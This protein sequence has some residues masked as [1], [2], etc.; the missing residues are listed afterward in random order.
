MRRLL[1]LLFTVVSFAASAQIYESGFHVTLNTLKTISDKDFIDRTSSAGI[2]LG[3]SKFLGERF[4]FGIEGGH[5]VLR[6]H[7]PYQTYYY[8]GGA[9]SY[10]SHR[11]VYYYTFMA[12][13]QY[14]F[15]QGKHFIP[16]ASLG[17]G[18]A[19]SQYRLYYNVYQEEDKK[20]AF[21]VRPEVGTIFRIKEHAG[22][23]LKAA[24]G[25]DYTTNK[26]DYF[27]TDNLSSLNVQF[28]FVFLTH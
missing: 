23:G 5:S 1:V 8:D 2:R 9:I 6:G 4:G 19:F 13:G 16:Y 17:L 11:F 10:E 18:V 12:N 3:Y 27:G 22:W 20:T 15:V 14:Y 21:A 26:S 24:V 25:Y 28:G 7:D